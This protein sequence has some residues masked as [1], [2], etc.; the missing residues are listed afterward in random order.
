MSIAEMPVSELS[1]P[2]SG[3]DL[4]SIEGIGTGAI[5]RVFDVTGRSIVAEQVRSDNADFNGFLAR[6]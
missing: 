6:G 2:Q 1:V 5:V 3:S 4:I